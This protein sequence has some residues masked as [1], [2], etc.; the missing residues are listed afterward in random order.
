MM[1][2]QNL[3]WDDY[4]K[5]YARYLHRPVTE[6]VKMAGDLKGKVVYD[7]CCG[8]GEIAKAALRRQAAHVVACDASPA[9]MGPLRDWRAQ[10]PHP[11]YSSRLRCVVFPIDKMLHWANGHVPAR[12][13]DQYVKWIAEVVDGEQMLQKPDVVLCRQGV[14]Y[15]LNKFT[16]AAL[17]RAMN[18]GGVFIFNTFNTRPGLKPVVKEYHYDGADFIETSW[19]IAKSG[20]VHHIQVREGMAPHETSFHWIPKGTLLRILEPHFAMV[21]QK[22]GKTSLYKCTRK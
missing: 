6:L 19:R 13:I 17:A 3:S 16:A 21:E 8:G 9:M 5:L 22:R 1:D 18:P 12:T 14:N 20:L 11:R 15:W 4:T 7:L 2:Y 10:K